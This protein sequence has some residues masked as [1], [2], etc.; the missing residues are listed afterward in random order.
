MWLSIVLNSGHYLMHSS[1]FIYLRWMRHQL[2]HANT[3]TG[4]QTLSL[5]GWACWHISLHMEWIW[6]GSLWP[7]ESAHLGIPWHLVCNCTSC[8]HQ[9]LC[10][11]VAEIGA[12][13]SILSQLC[14]IY[15][16]VAW[17]LIF[18]NVQRIYNFIKFYTIVILY[19]DSLVLGPGQLP[20]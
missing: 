12:S 20:Y 6:W 4:R 11:H 17:K 15:S 13:L 7:Q 2:G 8:S 3:Y 14:L 16:M 5:S 18:E 19:F 1:Y 9:P 10:W